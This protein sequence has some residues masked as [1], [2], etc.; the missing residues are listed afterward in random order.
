MQVKIDASKVIAMLREF[1]DKFFP[2]A[3]KGMEK[4]MHLFVSKIVREQMTGRPGLKRQTGTLAR[5]NRV[6]TRGWGKSFQVEAQFG[7]PNAPYVVV[8]QTGMHI[9]PKTKKR[10]A[11][12]DRKGNW[13]SASHVYIPKRLHIPEEFKRSGYD[14]IGGSVAEEISKQFQRMSR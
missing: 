3:Q 1:P 14:V 7:Y 5:A 4:G 13:F 11:W 6:V 12:Q 2:S 8:H 10:L 9:Y